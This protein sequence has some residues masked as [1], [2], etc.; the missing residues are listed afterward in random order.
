M[1]SVSRH[2]GVSI[3]TVTRLLVAAGETCSDFH[4]RAVRG[5]PA[6][7]IQ[8]DE[9]WSFC[10][11]KDRRAVSGIDRAG[12]VWTWTGIDVDTRLLVSWMCGGRDADYASEF[13][14]DL[15][16]RVR[17]RLHL[18]TDGYPHYAEAVAGAFGRRGVDYAQ[19]I[20]LY[21][22]RGEYTSSRKEAIYGDPDL[23]RAGTT[24]VERLNLTLRM[25]VRRYTRKVNAFSKKFANHVHHVALWS[26]WYNFMRPHASLG[27]GVTPAM[28]AGLTELPLDWRWL[29][30]EVDRR[31]PE[32]APR[33]LGVRRW[34]E[35]AQQPEP[36]PRQVMLSFD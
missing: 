18:T 29:L 6:R 21:G 24:Y 27:R 28:A 20:K 11:A 22:L 26:V 15:A 12:S 36:R 10:Y 25:A 30:D 23:R 31:A 33:L 4:D 9:I 16:S 14:H 2:L 5:V 19:L 34:L 13:M 3:N 7:R 1:R 35:A 32:P 8:C 17:G